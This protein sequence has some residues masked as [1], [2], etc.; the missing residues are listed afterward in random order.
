MVV[1]DSRSLDNPHY[2]SLPRRSISHVNSD[3]G[4]RKFCEFFTDPWF[5]VREESKNDYGV[6][7]VIE[8]LVNNGGHPTNIRC[9][10][11]IKSSNKKKNQ[12][13]SFSY[14]VAASNLNYLLNSPNSFYV[15]YSIRED[16]LYYC[17]AENAY[18]NHR[19]RKN[20][21]VRFAKILDSDLLKDIHSRMLD[22]TLS[23]RDLLLSP[24]KRM[25]L[26]ECEFVYT[27]DDDGKVLLMHNTIWE[28][29]H[30]EIPEGYEVYH[31]NGNFLD[32]R[33]A[34]LAIKETEHPFPI[35]EFQIEVSNAQMYNIL[36]IILEG[37]KA[38][39]VKD[40]PPPP[41]KMFTNI[42]NGLINQGW[43]I[44]PKMLSVLQKKM[45]KRLKLQI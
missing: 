41:K 17:S 10:A 39:L 23:I 19:G 6:D 22:I 2:G 38:Y 5:I 15:F 20:T 12:D 9:H 32:N 43:S 11:Q 29:E 26:N 34:N 27:T 24:D 25:L 45:R 30:G 14:S 21:T 36:S 37:D 1:P 42:V 28:S 3:L 4:V 16:M 35:E 31:V 7:L 18:R 33:Q 44:N 13:G 40:V 8:A